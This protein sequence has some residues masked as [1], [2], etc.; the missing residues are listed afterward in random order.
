MRPQ[1]GRKR[2][3]GG[4]PV[5]EARGGWAPQGRAD[6]PTPHTPVLGLPGSNS[7]YLPRAFP[8]SLSL[9]S[10][11]PFSIHSFVTGLSF[12][13][14]S[15]NQTRCEVGP[16]LSATSSLPCPNPPHLQTPC[17][18]AAKGTAAPTAL[19]PHPD[20]DLESF[21]P[22]SHAP[23]IRAPGCSLKGAQS[24]SAPIPTASRW[25]NYSDLRVSPPGLSINLPPRRPE[26]SFPGPL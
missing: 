13:S 20:P 25:D 15:T 26:W 5:E 6:L 7:L 21:P 2:V 11:F 14:P 9:L 17:I 16:N 22:P 3:A 10:H 12:L 19:P 4:S 1:R 23:P 8:S 24:P 18:P